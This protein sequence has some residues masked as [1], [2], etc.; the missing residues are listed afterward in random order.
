MRLSGY[1]S[2]PFLR[3]SPVH[4]GDTAMLLGQESPVLG[5]TNV[6]VS[7]IAVARLFGA[8]FHLGRLVQTTPDILIATHATLLCVALPAS[9]RRNTERVWRLY[10]A[11]AKRIMVIRGPSQFV[12]WAKART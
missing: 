7:G 8:T 11:M 1:V 5:K 6:C 10:S 3:V 2:R 4:G 9:I 12:G